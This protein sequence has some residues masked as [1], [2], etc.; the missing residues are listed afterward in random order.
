MHAPRCCLKLLRCLAV[1]ISRELAPRKLDET[2]PT[3]AVHLSSPMLLLLA[4]LLT[5]FTLPPPPPAVVSLLA[6]G[7]AGAVGAFVVFPIDTLKTRL[8]SEEGSAC[9]GNGVAAAAA[10]I[11]TEGPLSLYRGLG[12]Q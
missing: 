8:Q 2:R 9:Y 11:Q 5:A 4:T 6:A 3:G 1:A 7:T 12:P 10:L